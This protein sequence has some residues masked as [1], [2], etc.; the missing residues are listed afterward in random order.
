PRAPASQAP[1][2]HHRV[3]QLVCLRRR[4]R[5]GV[6]RCPPRLAPRWARAAFALGRDR[7]GTSFERF[8]SPSRRSFIIGVA[9]SL[10]VSASFLFRF[11][12][13]S[14]HLSLSVISRSSSGRFPDGGLGR[15]DHA[16]SIPESVRRLQTSC[17]SFAKSGMTY[18][19]VAVEQI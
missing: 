12:F 8:G 19:A 4:I 5:P 14:F 9:A 17:H 7:Y 6:C 11:S 16:M 18:F 1:V 3:H 2:E 13:G 10:P 15:C